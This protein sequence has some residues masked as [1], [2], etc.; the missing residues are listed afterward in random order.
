M[1]GM[2]RA[3]RRGEALR[4]SHEGANAAARQRGIADGVV[5]STG[6]VAVIANG[7][8]RLNG[9]DHRPYGS[10]GDMITML[11][12][13]TS[14]VSGLELAFDYVFASREL[15]EYGGSTYNDQFEL[16]VNGVNRAVLP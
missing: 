3:G 7:Q 4:R 2:P 9:F 10:G 6:Q 16:S 13:W 14:A 11:L 12:Q 8:M 5:L 15:P 1:P